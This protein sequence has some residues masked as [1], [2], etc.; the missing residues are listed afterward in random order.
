VKP[1]VGLSVEPGAD[2]AFAVPNTG[3]PETGFM[4]PEPP[5]NVS[6]VL[7]AKDGWVVPQVVV[8]TIS[9]AT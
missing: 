8:A 3:Q 5:V 2:D 9:K 6:A 7:P 4:N 1:V